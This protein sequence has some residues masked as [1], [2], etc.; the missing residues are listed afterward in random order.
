MFGGPLT[1][2][3]LHP[4]GDPSLTFDLRLS[5]TDRGSAP[6]PGSTVNVTYDPADAV[7][8]PERG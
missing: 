1:K 5:G 6:A 3:L 2:L 8:I 4:E 7:V